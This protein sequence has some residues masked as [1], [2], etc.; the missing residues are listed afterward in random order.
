[1]RRN[2]LIGFAAVFGIGFLS[3]CYVE[4][5][6]APSG[7]NGETD[8]AV[9]RDGAYH[10]GD[11]SDEEDGGADDRIIAGP[12]CYSDKRLA[13]SLFSLCYKDTRPCD[14]YQVRTRMILDTG[15]SPFD[16]RPDGTPVHEPRGF[17]LI[18]Q[19][20]ESEE[21]LDFAFGADE[22][23]DPAIIPGLKNQPYWKVEIAHS[24][25]QYCEG[26]YTE[27]EEAPAY[28]LQG[29]LDDVEFIYDPENELP[30]F[31]DVR[32]AEGNLVAD[33]R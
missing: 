4:P 23:I 22:T 5:G 1:M 16:V 18:G 27:T 6:H 11:S 33:L 12:W 8:S 31:I 21:S 13:D 7:M 30:L 28:W 10:P 2:I 9:V 15:N 17:L 19:C 24:V 25:I 14:G 32:D 29:S 20:V 3:G 26:C